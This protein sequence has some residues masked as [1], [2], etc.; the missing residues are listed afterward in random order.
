[1][2]LDYA[3]GD[4]AMG[5]ESFPM[6]SVDLAGNRSRELG[7]LRWAEVIGSHPTL[8]FLCLSKNEIGLTGAN[9]FRDFVFAALT[10]PALSVLDLRNN[11]PSGPG[12]HLMGPPPQE[13]VDDILCEIPS[14][15]FDESE[16]RQGVFIRRHRGGGGVSENRGRQP[17]QGQ[18]SNG[19]ARQG[20][21]S[22]HP[23]Q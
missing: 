12:K 8:Q 5:L 4:D 20:H 6:L 2:S 19:V 17:Q 14:G 7:A 15:E 16:V 22:R 18:Q 13:A 3:M 21:V 1:M 23:S 10:S 11:F 9:A